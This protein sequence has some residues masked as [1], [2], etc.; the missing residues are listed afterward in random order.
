M[1]RTSADMILL[2]VAS[3]VHATDN[4]VEELVKTDGIQGF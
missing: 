1:E 2:D 3:N 4:S